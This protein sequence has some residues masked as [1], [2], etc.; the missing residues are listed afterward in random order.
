M[1]RLREPLGRRG[2]EREVG[3]CAADRNE[4]QFHLL[5]DGRDDPGLRAVGVHH[6]AGALGQQ[7]IEQPELCRAIGLQRRMIVEMIAR[8]IRESAG[9]DSNTIEAALVEAVRRGFERE[10]RDAL[11][12]ELVEQLMQCHRIGR[13]QASRH[14]ARGRTD[15]E[16]AEA[17]GL[18]PGRS[19][20]LP[21]ERND[22]GLSVGAGDG[23]DR[24]RLARMQL[25]RR[26]RERGARIRDAHIDDIRGQ[27]RGPLAFADH[28][29]RALARRIG[30]E[31]AAIGAAAGEREEQR[32]RPGLAA[33]GGDRGDRDAARR[34]CAVGTE[35]IVQFRHFRS[36]F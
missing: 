10:M 27:A 7:R 16:R 22:R 3:A 1:E 6:G 32:S 14:L 12:R 5:R 26:A 15:A 25:R 9:R 19:P 34:I 17:G 29:D 13:G 4:T 30:R 18:M 8:E 11:A 28:G 24:F 33:I 2:D 20:D 23:D 21:R 36:E 31:A 35:Q